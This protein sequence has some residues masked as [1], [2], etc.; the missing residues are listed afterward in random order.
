MKRIL[1]GL[2]VLMLVTG[3]SPNSKSYVLEKDNQET[4]ETITNKEKT[5]EQQETDENKV[6]Q[7]KGKT[8]TSKS[9]DSKE[10]N[11]KFDD[12]KTTSKSDGKSEKRKIQKRRQAK[13]LIRIQ[14]PILN[15]NHQTV[16]LHLHPGVVVKPQI[17][18]LRTHQVHRINHL[19][20]HHH[21][22]M[23]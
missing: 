21:S 14:Q 6:N 4:T 7:E 18:T 19:I 20:I 15:Q 17:Q 12:K 13:N 9:N 2:L 5:D 11:K 10:E 8:D 3:C 16:V 22:K 23:R 1:I